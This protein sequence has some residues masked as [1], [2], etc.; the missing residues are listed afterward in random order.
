M[1]GKR[2]RYLALLRGINVGGHNLIS[3]SDLIDAFEAMGVE[4]VSTYIQ[5]GNV[6]FESKSIPI[7]RLTR[8]IETQLSERFDYEARAV[9]LRREDYHAAVHAA[10]RNWGQAADQKHNAMFLLEGIHAKD[11]LDSL[12]K[13]RPDIETISI[14]KGVIFW[15]ASIRHLSKT[16]MMALAKTRWYREMTVRNHKTTWRLAE[17]LDAE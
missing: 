2:T 7:A 12:P 13:P 16:A 17:L 4:R 3:K 10:H 8:Q 6:L 9:V 11:I 5:S 15:S 14:G 1:A